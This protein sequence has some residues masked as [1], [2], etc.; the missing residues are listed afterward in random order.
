MRTDRTVCIADFGL[1]ITKDEIQ[2]KQYPKVQSGTKRYFSPEA[3]DETLDVRCFES[4]ASADV[5]A[6]ALVFWESLNQSE[7]NPQAG[8]FHLPYH[9][10]TRSDPSIDEMKEVVV[11]QGRRPKLFDDECGH[12]EGES[13]LTSICAVVRRCWSSEPKDRLSSFQIKDKLDD[14]CRK[15]NKV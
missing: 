6:Y 15:L 12:H 3:L 14:L 9:E 1:S 8:T 7:F 10:Y 2:S 5:Y 11:V 4:F 13:T